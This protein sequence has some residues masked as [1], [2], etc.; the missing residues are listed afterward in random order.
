MC[1]IAGYIG[2]KQAAPILI[3]LLRRQQ[4]YD[5]GAG[6]GIA[7]IHNGVL[8]TAKVV[9]DVDEL[10]RTT[11]ALN[12]PGTIGI[13]H[14]RPGGDEVEHMHP[15]LDDAGRLALVANGIFSTTA[16]PEYMENTRRLMSGYYEK[17]VHIRSALPPDG[18]GMFFLPD[19]KRY[20]GTESYALRTG[21]F[22]ERGMP[23]CK[24]LA[25]TLSERPNAIVA[26]ALR[27]DEPDTIAIGKLNM[28]MSVGM[29]GEETY[30]ATTQFGFPENLVFDTVV[31]PPEGVVCAA[32]AGEL[33][34]TRHHV[35]NMRMERVTADI[36]KKA[37]DLIE[38]FLRG[39]KDDPKNLWDLEKMYMT[40]WKHIWQEPYSDCIYYKE[41]ALFK[42]YAELS[43]NVLF[44][45]QKEGKLH[46]CLKLRNGRYPM[47]H[48]YLD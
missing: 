48:F 39:R 12:F 2:N 4:Y 27:V 28:P 15:F 11:D 31:Q 37:Y 8:Y 3:D 7:T 42:P 33:T 30:I 22:C 43:Y 25:E 21:E 40:E 18:T 5:G 26:V 46:K 14:S 35:R 34:V 38:A 29:I 10:L 24:A 13:A 20:H 36:F 32:R 44:A 23:L 9:G 19:G 47:Y 1:N 6:T 16:T 45:M 41:D 17:G